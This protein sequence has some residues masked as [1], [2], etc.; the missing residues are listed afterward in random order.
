[1]DSLSIL[2][3]A[4]LSTWL[5]AAIRLAGP[6][7]LAALGE[8]FAERSGVLNI[9][10]EG[11][12]LIGALAAYLACGLSGSSWLGV[13]AA[14]VSGWLASL[15][16]SW[17]YVTVQASQVVV[18]IVFN[19]LA[20]GA[21]SLVFRTTGEVTGGQSVAMFPALQIPGLSELP[22]VGPALFGQPVLL[23][24]TLLLVLVASMVLQR[25]R[26]GLSLRAVGENPRAADA[27]GISVK[28]MRHAGVWISGGAAGMAGAYL[29][30]CEVGV[31]RDSIVSGQ[32]F[33]ALAIVILGRWTPWK[34]MLAALVFG[35]AD[36]LQLS[37]QLLGWG[38]PPQL[39]LALPYALTLLAISGM[40]GGKS[41]QPAALLMPHQ[42]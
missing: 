3:A 31:Y 12:L 18:G 27:A 35:L 14:I 26:F 38:L 41:V 4:F 30:L 22:W 1:M 33:I 16:L 21:C 20:L 10:I 15:L 2:D 8:V 9:G 42:R 37:L 7:L 19:L 39:L 25:S 24:V 36:A 32:G 28:R 11:L 13:F 5:A 29:M 6:V 34:V 23:Y 40:F 17:L